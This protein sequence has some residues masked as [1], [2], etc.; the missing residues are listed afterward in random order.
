MPTPPG[1]LIGAASHPAQET[2]GDYF[3][4]LTLAD[5]SLAVA[6]G[7]A[8]GHGIGAALLMAET[9]AF[10][11]ALALTRTDLGHILSLINRR[12]TEDTAEDHYVTMLLARVIPHRGTLSY[13]SAGHWPGLVFDAEGAVKAVLDSTGM[14][15]GFDLT[16]EYPLAPEVALRPGDLVLLGTDGFAEA[17]SPADEPF[18]KERVVELVRA[19]RHASPQHIVDVLAQSVREFAGGQQPDDMTAVVLKVEGPP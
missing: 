10:L 14:V 18:G 8:S 13:A 9:R 19:H 4:F 6:V 7:D 15:L 12:L 3:D 16:C 5:G 11:R 1:L 17:F 2:G